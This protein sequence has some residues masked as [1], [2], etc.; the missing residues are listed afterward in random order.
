MTLVGSRRHYKYPENEIIEV[1]N[2]NW[3]GNVF[4]STF[5][6]RTWVTLPPKID[7]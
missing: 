4:Y 2:I 7:S 5:R 1:T 3:F 6:R